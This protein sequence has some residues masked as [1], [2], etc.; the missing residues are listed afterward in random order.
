MAVGPGILSSGR[1]RGVRPLALSAHLS[2]HPIPDQASAIPSIDLAE[3]QGRSF[4]NHDIQ[5]GTITALSDILGRSPIAHRHDNYLQ[6][7]HVTKGSFELFNDTRRTEARG[8]AIF[9]TPA[10]VPHAFA[11]SLDAGGH[12][13]T[14]SQHLV[15]RIL[16]RD[17]S[18]PGPEELAPFCIE[19][20]S[21]DQL[22]VH[23]RLSTLYGLLE[24]EL[25]ESTRGGQ[26]ACEGLVQSILALTLGIQPG[27]GGEPV[28]VPHQQLPLYRRFLGL[29][30]QHY[31]DHRPVT[32]FAQLMGLT[33]WHLFELVHA[34]G[35]TTPKSLLRDR[36]LQE[37]KRQ[38]AFSTASVKEVA[39]HLGFSDTAYFCRFFKMKL[40]TTPSAYRKQMQQT[41]DTS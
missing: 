28:S 18:L 29:V 17:R 36:L 6:I 16:E 33:E 5:Y 20:T 39:A 31:R 24:L 30:E 41:V 2:A 3:I 32:F 35:S 13:L 34:C 12:V 4:N 7:H 11:F 8:P 1:S 22:A 40:G 27:D 14:L 38:L 19:F 26:A 21:A 25:E 37:A 10:A 15:R 23:A 9:V